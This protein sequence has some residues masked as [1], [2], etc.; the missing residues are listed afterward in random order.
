MTGA[1]ILK[2]QCRVNERSRVVYFF[3]GYVAADIISGP[4]EQQKA[5]LALV[6]QAQRMA[7]VLS[8]LLPALEGRTPLGD[9]YLSV[10]DVLRDAK[11]LSGKPVSSEGT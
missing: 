4:E 8:D 9:R 2:S 11:V 3:D 1:D 5:V 7:Q 6:G 10:I